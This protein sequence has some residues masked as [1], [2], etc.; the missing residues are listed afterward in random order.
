MKNLFKKTFI[1]LS[2]LVFTIVFS[3]NAFAAYNKTEDWALKKI[4]ILEQLK[5]KQAKIEVRIEKIIK[6][7]ERYQK[8]TGLSLPG[9][10]GSTP[11]DPEE[12]EEAD[13]EDPTPP[14]PPQVENPEPEVPEVE[15]PVA[16]QP[17]PP[18]EPSEHIN[19]A[20][21]E[22]EWLLTTQRD[23]GAFALTPN[24]AHINPYY[25][26]MTV[27][28]LLMLDGKYA[29]EAKNYLDW[30][31][32]HLNVE[33]DELGLT[34]TIYDY[35]N[36]NGEEIPEYVND[37]NKKDY[38]SSDAYAGTFLSLMNEYHQVTGDDAYVMAHLNELFLIAGAIDAT[39]Q[40]FGLTWAKLDYHAAYMMDNTEVWR[41]YLDFA[42]LLDRLGNSRAPEF[43]QKADDVEAAIEEHLWDEELQGY[44]PYKWHKLIWSKYY[45]DARANTR[46]LVFDLPGALERKEILFGTFIENHPEWITNDAGDSPNMASAI[47]AIKAGYVDTAQEFLKNT[48]IKFEERKWP[49][50]LSES[51]YYIRVLLLLD[52][53]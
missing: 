52:E 2:I 50:K 21:E 19:L 23:S 27:Q 33:P 8:M 44:T 48:L 51:A 53:L 39:M 45:P 22:A 26:N 9:I 10:P 11:E 18:Q 36:V 6:L 32:D 29:P 3:L 13:T 17:E 40:D 25:A 14:V 24:S 4:T 15:E 30:Y 38:D 35:I 47:A 16:P 5:E 37:P 41:G 42:Q 28:A 7:L 31:F 1:C 20:H 34:G 43:Q 46:A 49:W 12:A